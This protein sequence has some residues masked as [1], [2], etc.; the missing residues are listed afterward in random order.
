M[1][2]NL[3]GKIDN[4]EKA[5]RERVEYLRGKNVE[6]TGIFVSLQE[7]E[8]VE[9]PRK[10]EFRFRRYAYCV[11]YSPLDLK[12]Y[13][14]DKLTIQEAVKWS[15]TQRWRK[16]DGSLFEVEDYLRTL[17]MN[18]QTCGTYK[19]T[20][21]N[22]MVY[23]E[24]NIVIPYDFH[25]ITSPEDF[26]LPEELS[27]LGLTEKDWNFWFEDSLQN[28]YWEGAGRTYL[29]EPSFTGHDNSYYMIRM[30]PVTDVFINGKKSYAFNLT[31]T[32][33]EQIIDMIKEDKQITGEFISDGKE[34]EKYVRKSMVK[35]LW[36]ERKSK[37][38]ARSI[39]SKQIY[40]ERVTENGR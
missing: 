10:I 13:K 18:E 3:L 5:R 7:K 29:K 21:P 4:S 33:K 15:E 24:E 37:D 16:G 28:Y 35:N 11:G 20:P 32:E 40:G 6:T 23:D 26:K 22:L 36:I 25:D 9:L 17:I 2:S 8:T 1:L 27:A 14:H 34:I 38:I 30:E 39:N 12:H 31:L 19:F